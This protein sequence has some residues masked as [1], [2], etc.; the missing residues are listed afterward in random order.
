MTISEMLAHLESREVPFVQAD[1]SID[2]VIRVVVR[3]PH[4][5]LAYVVDDERQLVGTI[6]IGSLLRHI[7]PHHYEGR[8]HA[9]GVLRR[10]T[11]ETARSIMDKGNLYA[12]PEETVDEVLERMAE[13]GAKEMAVVDA[14]RCVIGD[15][16]AVDL[17]RYYYLETQN[18][19]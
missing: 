13:T 12:T 5:R 8:V 11:A 17:L 9:H 16:T 7:F 2:D 10:I 3:F 1:G 14:D 4:T 6:T 18:P 19:E 15:I